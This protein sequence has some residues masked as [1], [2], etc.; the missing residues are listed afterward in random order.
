MIR[1]ACVAMLAMASVA[2]ASAFAQGTHLRQGFWFNGGFGL[3]T[4]GCQDCDGRTNSY[5]G[6][7]AIGGTLNQHWLLGFGTNG[8]TKSEDGTTLTVGTFT[9]LA[10]FYPSAT[11]SFFLLGGVGVGTVNA[12]LSGLGSD[13]ETGAGALLGV[14]Y[15]I[16]VGS[17]ASI[18]PFWN[19]FAVN[20]SAVDANVGQLGVGVTI[21]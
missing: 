9:A 2:P 20:N 19:G 12:E 10:R 4:L 11:G 14:G 7:L 18:T 6:G 3:G 15:D 1:A 5:S 17:A 21:H 8:W 13:T 16:H